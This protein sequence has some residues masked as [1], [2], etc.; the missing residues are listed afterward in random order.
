MT[1]TILILIIAININEKEKSNK[2][3]AKNICASLNHMLDIPKHI[4][5]ER[6]HTHTHT[7]TTTGECFDKRS[8]N[9]R[10]NDMKKDKKQLDEVSSL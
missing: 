4:R 2:A 7:H 10:M 3:L 6:M 8:V 1:V 9:V 5:S